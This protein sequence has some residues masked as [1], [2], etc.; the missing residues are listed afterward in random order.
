MLV[1]NPLLLY[2]V[3]QNI[4]W[5]IWERDEN[6]RRWADHICAFINPELMKAT[7]DAKKVLD[8]TLQNRK[9]K[10]TSVYS[11]RVIDSITKG[12]KPDYCNDGD[13]EI[14]P[15]GVDSDAC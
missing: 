4:A 8:T 14:M 9:P 5:D 1:D 10:P 15:G 3:S 11:K 2:W 12:R 7:M 13:D 6:T